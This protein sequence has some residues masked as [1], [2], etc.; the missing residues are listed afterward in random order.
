MGAQHEVVL[1]MSAAITEKKAMAGIEDRI[2]ARYKHLTRNHQ[3]IID[4]M[5]SN[6]QDAAF[7]PARQIGAQIGLS[8][9]TVIRLAYALGYA[10]FPALQSAVREKFFSYLSNVERLQRSQEADDSALSVYHRMLY[11]DI[12]NI[13]SAIVTNSD[14]AFQR[15]ER[16]I[17]KARNIYIIGLRK[18]FALASYLH[19]CLSMMLNNSNLI[20]TA[21]GDLP[22]QLKKIGPEDLVV[23]ICF[24]RYSTIAVD[25]FRWA[26]LCGAKTL[27]VTDSVK[28]PIVSSGDVGLI[29]DTSRS[30]SFTESLVGPLAVIHA[31]VVGVSLRHKEKAG[32]TLRSLETLYKQ[33]GSLYTLRD[34]VEGTRSKS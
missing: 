5:L 24:R 32:K 3:R 7:V 15:A 23:G 25:A 13:R 16:L 27:A 33:F 28:S 21:M 12:E 6:P 29:C 9:S 20:D 2:K 10:G 18:S 26:K 4:L 19:F 17:A 30:L 14:A 31:L 11:M 1:T 22:E 8:E 34:G